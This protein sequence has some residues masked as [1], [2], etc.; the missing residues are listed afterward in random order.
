[1]YSIAWKP[2]LLS[3]ILAGTSALVRA[4]A[5]SLQAGKAGLVVR[6]R[7]RV[8]VLWSLELLGSSGAVGK[9]SICWFTSTIAISCQTDIA[10][11]ASNGHKYPQCH[12]CPLEVW[13]AAVA[14]ALAFYPS[15]HN[16]SL[17]GHCGRPF[18]ATCT[19]QQ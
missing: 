9:L 17:W 10:A 14:S 19:W 7:V 3:W 5:K 6:V 15:V 1:M 13:G 8:R 18:K 12:R 4:S 2:Q 16:G 11:G